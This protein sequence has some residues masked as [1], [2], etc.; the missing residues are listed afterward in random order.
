MG[1]D[2]ND[3]MNA[4]LHKVLKKNAE[5]VPQ[6]HVIYLELTGRFTVDADAQQKTL[7]KDTQRILDLLQKP[8]HYGPL[9]PGDYKLSLE[10]GADCPSDLKD[11]PTSSG[12]YIGSYDCMVVLDIDLDGKWQFMG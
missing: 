1:L 11:G 12:R 4:A 3:E 6:G 10:V 9:K 8:G 5:K 2:Y 7:D